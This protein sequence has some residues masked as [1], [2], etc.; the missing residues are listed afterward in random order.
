MSILI[1]E[2]TSVLVQGITGREGRFHTLQMLNYGT[3][4]VAGVTPG[5]GGDW[6][7]IIPVFDTVKTA[8]EVTGA[9][10]SLICVPAAHAADAIY[11]AVDA[12]IALVVC[13]TV[14][15]PVHDM[16]RIYRYMSSSKSRLIGP[17]CPGLLTPGK[18]KVGIMPNYIASPGYVGVVGKTGT[19]TYEVVYALTRA[20][21]GQSTFV[22]IGSDPIVGTNF[23]EILEMFE[24]DLDTEKVAIVGEIGGR[25]EIDAAEYIKTTMTKP[26]A[27]FIAGRSAPQGTQ[28]GHA[29]AI[30][31]SSE[32]SADE[33]I[34]ALQE[35]GV[36]VTS[37]PE[38][39]PNLLI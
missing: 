26:V 29:G 10:T 12:G 9:N 24:H 30:I 16:M 7:E 11:E 28:M 37:N 1:D 31:E 14:G 13:I 17:N 18:S 23:V 25:A 22:G 34:R 20:G 35:A 27:A 3:K 19:L 36:R 38:E 4:V 21:L 39:I 2:N 32:S 33:K 5:K 6:V 15:I 8:V